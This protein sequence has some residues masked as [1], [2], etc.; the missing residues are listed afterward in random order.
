MVIFSGVG[1][2]VWLYNI[3]ISQ[4]GVSIQNSRAVIIFFFNSQE[5]LQKLPQIVNAAEKVIQMVRMIYYKFEFPETAIFDQTGSMT[6]CH[7][8]MFPVRRN[9]TPHK[10][11]RHFEVNPQNYQNEARFSVARVHFHLVK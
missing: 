1:W 2:S 5:R 11:D 3:S 10:I 7:G 9:P 8:A 6:C 4:V